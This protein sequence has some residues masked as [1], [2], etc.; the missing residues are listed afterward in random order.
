[1]MWISVS[2][3]VYP[4]ISELGSTFACL[5]ILWED[6]CSV[7]TFPLCVFMKERDRMA[8]PWEKED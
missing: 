5:R 3:F 4:H 7:C 8:N 6:E 2:V 1:M